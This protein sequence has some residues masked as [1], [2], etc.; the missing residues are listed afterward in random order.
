M[1]VCMSIG[2]IVNMFLYH[3]ILGRYTKEANGVC[4]KKITVGNDVENVVENTVQLSLSNM[5]CRQV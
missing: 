1:T 5:D 2:N 4:V 3:M